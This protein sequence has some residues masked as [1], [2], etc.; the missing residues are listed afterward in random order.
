MLPL[1]GITV[2]SLEQAV[3]APLPLANW[4]IWIARVI[5]IERPDVGTLRAVRCDRARIVSTLYGSID[6][7]GP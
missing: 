4:R 1:A 5:K 6:Q 3:A 7:K 2:V